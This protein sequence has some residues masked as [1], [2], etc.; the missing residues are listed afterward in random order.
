MFYTD[1]RPASNQCCTPPD[2]ALEAVSFEHLLGWLDQLTKVFE[3][4][5]TD[6][7]T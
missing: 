6:N 5:N 3:V 2:G 4:T 7:L 1:H